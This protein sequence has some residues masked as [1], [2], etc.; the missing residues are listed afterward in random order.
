MLLVTLAAVEAAAAGGLF[1]LRRRLVGES[2]AA[3]MLIVC[4]ATVAALVVGTVLDVSGVALAIPV[5]LGM[6]WVLRVSR[7][8]PG[9]VAILAMVAAAA[10]ALG[11]QLAATIDPDTGSYGDQGAMLLALLALPLGIAAAISARWRTQR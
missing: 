2:A 1:W 8:R 4:L 11:Y 5:M 6:G 3:V 7:W 9:D 10:S